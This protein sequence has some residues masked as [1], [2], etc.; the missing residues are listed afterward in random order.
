METTKLQLE[1]KEATLTCLKNELKFE[2][3]VACEK[4]NSL[5]KEHLLSLQSQKTKYQA[6]IKRHQKF[7]EKL[8]SEK[9]DLTEKCNSLAQ[10]IKEI[11][12]KNQR[13]IKVIVERHSIEIQRA[14]ELCAASEKIRR[15]R[16]LE[17]KKNKI[18]V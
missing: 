13:E 9:K 15:E 17:A 18:K 10:R 2:R 12:A 1:E 11:E 6:I 8:I 7:I 5:K 16:W 3:K 14:K 4:L